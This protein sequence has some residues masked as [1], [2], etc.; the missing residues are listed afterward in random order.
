MSRLVVFTPEA[1]EDLLELY[2]YIAE[3]GSPDRAMAYIERVEKA[4]MSLRT[5]PE[6]GTR[7]EDLRPGLRVMGFERRA[8]IAF[9]V[10]S[11]SVAIL[12]I[13]YGGRSVDRAFRR[14]IKIN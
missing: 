3:H 2:N 8:A 14:A 9:R 1:R 13:L 5:I 7:R 12:R 10:N 4:C 11:D 6:R